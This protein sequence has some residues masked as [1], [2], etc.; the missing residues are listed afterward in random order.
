M[1]KKKHL[2]LF[3][4]TGNRNQESWIQT[5]NHPISFQGYAIAILSRW[6]LQ[7]AK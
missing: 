5:Q 7:N 6:E 3:P 4:L 2:S 1:K